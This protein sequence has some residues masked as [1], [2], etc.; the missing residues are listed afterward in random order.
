MSRQERYQQLTKRILTVW[1]TTA[2]KDAALLILELDAEMVKALERAVAADPPP[3]GMVAPLPQVVRMVLKASL[4]EH[5]FL[6]KPQVTVAPA[7]AR[8]KVVPK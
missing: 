2:P 1:K 7:G 5:G 6:L 8:L 4:L 3:A